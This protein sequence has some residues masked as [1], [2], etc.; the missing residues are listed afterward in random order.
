MNILRIRLTFPCE[1][2][3]VRMSSGAMSKPVL[4]AVLLLLRGRSTQSLAVWPMAPQFLQ[5]PFI[6]DTRCRRKSGRRQRVA[7]RVSM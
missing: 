6:F 2:R 4:S 1:A 3:S 5:A 7:L